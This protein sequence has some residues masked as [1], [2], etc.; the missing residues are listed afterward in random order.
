MWVFSTYLIDQPLFGQF[1]V[2]LPLH[3]AARLCSPFSY[4][5]APNGRFATV[6]A[7]WAIVSG[8]AHAL[9]EKAFP[10]RAHTAQHG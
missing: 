6:M 8:S 1:C 7:L 9:I 3:G 4:A 5:V 10:Q 2:F